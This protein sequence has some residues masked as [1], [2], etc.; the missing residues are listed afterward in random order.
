MADARTIKSLRIKIRDLEERLRAVEKEQRNIRED[1]L[2]GTPEERMQR[3][4]L[5]KPPKNI[6]EIKEKLDKEIKIEI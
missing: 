6:K 5:E 4:L 3:R 1:I 2:S